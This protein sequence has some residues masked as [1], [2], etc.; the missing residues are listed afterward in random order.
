MPVE[1]IEDPRCDAC[2]EPATH[3]D[4]G[5]FG[6]GL[7]VEKGWACNEHAISIDFEPIEEVFE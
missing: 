1:L 3:V 5:F 7:D 6:H 2:L 4:V